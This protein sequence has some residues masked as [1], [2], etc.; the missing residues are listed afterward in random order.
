[1]QLGHQVVAQLYVK[2][3]VEK[4]YIRLSL[5]LVCNKTICTSTAGGPQKLHRSGQKPR[6]QTTLI[7]PNE[8]NPNPP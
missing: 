3:S 5:P 4:K 7:M 8:V 2:Y 6:D 1:M